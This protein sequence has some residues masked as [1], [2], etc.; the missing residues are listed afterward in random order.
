MR[1]VHDAQLSNNRTAATHLQ[2]LSN[3]LRHALQLLVSSLQ[4]ITNTR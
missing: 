2:G 4:R 1:G 3:S